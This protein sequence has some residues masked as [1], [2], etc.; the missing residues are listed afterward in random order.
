MLV[1]RRAFGFLGVGLV[2]CAAGNSPAFASPSSGMGSFSVFRGLSKSGHQDLIGGYFDHNIDGFDGPMWRGRMSQ[3]YY[4][5]VPSAMAL[6]ASNFEDMQSAFSV[7]FMVNAQTDQ[8]LPIHLRNRLRS[9]MSVIPA[10][11]EGAGAM[12]KPVFNEHLNYL[13]S[14]FVR[15]LSQV[16]EG[17]LGSNLDLSNGRFQWDRFPRLTI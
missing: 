9:A 11:D 16:K 13:V 4:A 3:N 12:Q 7:D 5:V 10:F 17:Y 15:M 14:G 8:T 1:N 2:A 6:G